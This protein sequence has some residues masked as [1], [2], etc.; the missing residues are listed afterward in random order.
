MD[1]HQRMKIIAQEA[2][3]WW[4]D[5]ISSQKFNNG[6]TNTENIFISTLATLNV[7]DISSAQLCAFKETLY[8][9]ILERMQCLDKGMSIIMGC[10]YVPDKNLKEIA[11]KYDIPESNFPWKTNMWIYNDACLVIYGYDSNIEYIYESEYYWQR[12]L[13]N[14]KKSIDYWLEEGKTYDDGIIKRLMIEA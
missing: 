13:E 9:H 2:S 5:V 10:D 1:K 3:N 12:K 8:N 4:I 14:N 7:K 6:A 11:N